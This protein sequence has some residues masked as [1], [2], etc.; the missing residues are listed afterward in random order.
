MRRNLLLWV[1]LIF[2][3]AWLSFLILG[4]IA[5]VLKISKEDGIVEY[6]TALFY[7]IGFAVGIYSLY[8]RKKMSSPI[9]IPVIWTIL[10]FLFLGE[11]TSWFQRIFNYSVSS[12]ESISKQSEFNLHN[13]NIF[14]EGGFITDDG[15]INKM[16][17]TERL[18][19]SQNIFRMGFFGYFL[20][21]PILWGINGKI[22]VIL[23][24]MGYVKPSNIMLIIMLIV[25]AFSFALAVISPIDF[26]PPIAESREMLYALFIL[27][28]MIL[29]IKPSK[30][31]V[32]S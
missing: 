24:R 31:Q 25:F 7:L 26:K 11:E 9:V 15:K 32:A 5:Y 2:G 13:L 28:Y 27:I 22:M 10:C 4:D 14:N 17:L 20:I 21:I 3:L 1:F 8:H 19:S 23:T 29:Y 18:F 16:S 6:T 12:V 30:K